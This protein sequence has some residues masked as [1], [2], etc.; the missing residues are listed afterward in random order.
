MTRSESTEHTL[1][2]RVYRS[3]LRQIARGEMQRGDRL[4]IEALAERLGVSPT[5]VREALSRLESTGLVVHPRNRG[6][7]I[8]PRLSAGQF[9]RLMDARELIEVGAIGLAASE[10]DPAFASSLH[11]ALEEQE[12]AVQQ[13][14][15]AA[16]DDAGTDAAWA[17][18]DADLEFHR[19]ILEGSQNHFVRLMADS[20]SGQSHRIRQSAEHGVS[21]ALE[22]LAEHAAIVRAAQAGDRVAVES[23]MRLHIR[24]VRA[25]GH[26]D[27]ET[28]TLGDHDDSELP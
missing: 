1:S 26:R 13:F 3:I 22:A 16:T 21:D 28:E 25:R 14:Q 17:V 15:T 27:I 24:L 7:H 8:S 9:D 6:F 5:P 18:I 11:R 4:R 10:G 12:G 19:V 2:E 23:A 20:L